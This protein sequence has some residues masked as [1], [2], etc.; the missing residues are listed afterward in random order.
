MGITWTRSNYLREREISY[1]DYLRV[2][3]SCAGDGIEPS[4]GQVS[5]SHHLYDSYFFREI[6]RRMGKQKLKPKAYH[7]PT[8]KCVVLSTSTLLFS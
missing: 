1:F 4:P 2:M 3:T 6:L 8:K 5:A 7:T